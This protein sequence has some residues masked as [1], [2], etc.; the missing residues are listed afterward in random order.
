MHEVD[1]QHMQTKMG[2][3]SI[4]VVERPSERALIYIF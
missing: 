3:N 2:L 4:A 1:L